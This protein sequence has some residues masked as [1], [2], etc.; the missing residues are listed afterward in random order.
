MTMSLPAH[1][2]GIPSD[3]VQED[4][5]SCRVG[6]YDYVDIN[7]ESHSRNNH[8]E[9][10]EESEDEHEVEDPSTCTYY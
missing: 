4:A 8:E 7:N 5:H 9:A 3:L 2:A 1:T 10:T 6:A